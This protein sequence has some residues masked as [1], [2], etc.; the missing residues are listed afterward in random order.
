MAPYHKGDG[1]QANAVFLE[2]LADVLPD[3]EARDNIC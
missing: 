2:D 3:P 1:V